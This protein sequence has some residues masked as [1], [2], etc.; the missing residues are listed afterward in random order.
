MEGIGV[1]AVRAAGR[2]VVSWVKPS[3]CTPA[4]QWNYAREEVRLTQG[5]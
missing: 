3:L 2:T 5:K 4:G 1:G